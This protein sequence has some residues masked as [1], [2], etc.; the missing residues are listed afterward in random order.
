M[1]VSAETLDD[2][3][4]P[5]RPWFVQ[6][7]TALNDSVSD[8]LYGKLMVPPM[9]LWTDPPYGTGKRFTKGD[10]S[11]KDP[12][13]VE[14]TLEAITS[15]LPYMDPEG[16][17]VVC[18]DYRLAPILTYALPWHYRGEIIWEFGLG[19]PG[20]K[21][22]W[23]AKHN[24]L[25]MFTRTPTSGIFHPEA[26]PRTKRLSGPMTRKVVKGKQYEYPKVYK[27][28][29]YPADKPSG[30]VWDYTYGSS[31]GRRVGY[32]TE[33]PV[34]I[35]TPFV[36]AHT[37]PGDLVVDPYMGSGTTGVAA[38]Q[39]RRAFYGRDISSEAVRIATERLSTVSTETGEPQ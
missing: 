26:V 15:W 16:T 12:L 11:Y 3:W 34:E 19:N 32:P 17:V 24:N 29:E 33:K 35:I 20:R 4:K 22:W 38:L 37:N 10:A 30:S 27:T 28:Y 25:L 13:E 2:F 14:P 31:D 6:Q 18:C 23:P 39:Q 1:D 9:L 21:K 7:R 5:E 36:L 8:M